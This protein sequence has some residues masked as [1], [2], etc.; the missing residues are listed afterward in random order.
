MAHCGEGGTGCL[1]PGSS[2]KTQDIREPLMMGPRGINGRARIES[3]LEY[4][5]HN[6]ERGVGDGPASWRARHQPDL[7]VLE[8]DC[9]SHRAEHS[10]MRVDH[11]GGR[12]HP[13][14]GVGAS[15]RHAEIAP[16][17]VA[18]ATCPGD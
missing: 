8:R 14:R 5:E 18:E 2:L 13:A 16:I 3:E 12:A 10:F 4:I 7:A 11:I 15:W 17:A 6:P 9:G 1:G